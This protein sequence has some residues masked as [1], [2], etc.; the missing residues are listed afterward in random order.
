MKANYLNSEITS[1][2]IEQS[3]INDFLI[4]SN[5][6]RENKDTIIKKRVPKGVEYKKPDSDV[7]TNF[8][9][10][11]L[12]EVESTEF[13]IKKILEHCDSETGKLFL[14]E[15]GLQ[16]NQISVQSYLNSAPTIKIGTV[17]RFFRIAKVN[18]KN[19][20][21]VL[22]LQDLKDIAS[23]QDINTD[24]SGW[25]KVT[26]PYYFKNEETKIIS[27]SDGLFFLLEK[28]KNTDNFIKKAVFLGK[29]TRTYSQILSDIFR[30]AVAKRKYIFNLNQIK[31][32]TEKEPKITDKK[33]E[34][35]SI[36]KTEKPTK[37]KK[38]LQVA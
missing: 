11:I 5:F 32:E 22:S 31:K 17:T 20:H 7:R 34:T 9:D 29:D 24:V 15:I 14:N 8:L 16:K 12:N 30:N 26:T 3:S 6:E 37:T 10:I 27:D 33:T 23:S 18:E 36:P 21:K 19:E 25:Y 35:V 13:K 38:V 2:I 4:A 28:E 1:E